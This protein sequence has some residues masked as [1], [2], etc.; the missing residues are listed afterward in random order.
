MLKFSQRISAIMAG[1][2]GCFKQFKQLAVFHI[3]GHFHKAQAFYD[4][5]ENKGVVR[6]SLCW[7]DCKRGMRQNLV[8]L[9]DEQ[10]VL[11]KLNEVKEPVIVHV[12]TPATV[13]VK[14]VVLRLGNLHDAIV[15]ENNSQVLYGRPA[16]RKPIPDLKFSDFADGFKGIP[17]NDYRIRQRLDEIKRVLLRKEITPEI[18]QKAWDVFAVRMVMHS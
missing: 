18:L 14:M 9:G 1:R 15:A 13:M 5:L 3:G 7:G 12:P 2:P 10:D 8:F 17:T 6:L 4:A 11:A 16:Q